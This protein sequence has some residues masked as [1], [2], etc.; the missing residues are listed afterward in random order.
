MY[1]IGM[2]TTRRGFLRSLTAALATLPALRPDGLAHVARTTTAAGLRTPAELAGDEDFWLEIQQAF[3]VDR[4]LINL[5][6][7]GVSPSP[8]VVQEAMRRYLELS[9]QAPV[10]TMW[11]LV[12]PQVESVRRRPGRRGHPGGLH[13]GRQ[14]AEPVFGAAGGRRRGRRRLGT[15][16]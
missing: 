1:V 11:Q 13:A 14:G 8:R 16:K 9:N 12:E 2:D 4:T 5:N 6:N 10:Y 3:T 15:P 7:G